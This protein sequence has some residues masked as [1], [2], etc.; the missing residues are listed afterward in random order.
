MSDVQRA[1]IETRGETTTDDEQ[2]ATGLDPV[3]LDALKEADEDPSKIILSTPTLLGYYSILCL[4]INRMIGKDIL[5][6]IIGTDVVPMLM[7]PFS[8]VTPAG[9]TVGKY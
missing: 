6:S 2:W 3:D 9:N 5:G 1:S 8:N 4:V 7:L